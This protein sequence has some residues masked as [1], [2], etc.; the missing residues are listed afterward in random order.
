MEPTI[1]EANKSFSAQDGIKYNNDLFQNALVY[2]WPEIEKKRGGERRKLKKENV[3]P[4]D[5]RNVL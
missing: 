1:L 4:D 2:M 5:D 3:L